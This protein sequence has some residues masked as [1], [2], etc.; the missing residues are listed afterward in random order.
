[1]QF[2]G[3]ADRTPQTLAADSNGMQKGWFAARKDGGRMLDHDRG[4]VLRSQK[5]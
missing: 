2:A 4:I 3:T 5:L 1:M